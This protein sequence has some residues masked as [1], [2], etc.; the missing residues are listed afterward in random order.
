MNIPQTHDEKNMDFTS[1]SFGVAYK[2]MLT[3]QTKSI[4]IPLKTIGNW[5]IESLVECLL[6]PLDQ[7]QSQD[8]VTII[9]SCADKKKFEIANRILSCADKKKFERANRNAQSPKW[10]GAENTSHPNKTEQYRKEMDVPQNTDGN[11][12]Y[13]FYQPQSKNHDSPPGEKIREDS[14]NY[15]NHESKPRKVRSA[16]ETEYNLTYLFRVC[17]CKGDLLKSKAEAIW[18]G[19]DSNVQNTLEMSLVTYPPIGTFWKKKFDN[20]SYIFAGHKWT[21]Q[22]NRNIFRNILKYAGTNKIRGLALTLSLKGYE[23]DPKKNLA[24]TWCRS[25]TDFFE[26]TCGEPPL[27]A[28]YFVN[29]DDECLNIV[30]N[31]FAGYAKQLPQMKFQRTQDESSNRKKKQIKFACS[32]L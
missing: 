1:E 15:Q 26:E 4:L 25:V 14:L 12:K 32:I 13:D 30:N 7:I 5:T 23:T 21:A 22:D 17:V 29:N 8:N 2:T 31:Y 19:E 10:K 27:L 20:G 28:V 6:R 24:D 18:C 11:D 9:L 3:F 16:K